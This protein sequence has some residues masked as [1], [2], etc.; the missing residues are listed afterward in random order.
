MLLVGILWIVLMTAICYV[1]IEV[2]ANMQKG[3]LGIELTISDRVR[4]GRWSKVGTGHAP[5]G[6]LTPIVE[7]FNPFHH[8]P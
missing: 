1:G 8:P 2:S 7:W 6:H 3:L 4:R 5:P